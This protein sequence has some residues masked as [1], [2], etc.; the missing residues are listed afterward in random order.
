MG[1][2]ISEISAVSLTSCMTLRHVGIMLNIS[3]L[4]ALRTIIMEG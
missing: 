2:V 4:T 3:E 1:S